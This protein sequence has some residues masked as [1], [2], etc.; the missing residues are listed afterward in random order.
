M[1]YGKLLKEALRGAESVGAE[2]K[3][4]QL[5]DLKYT[6]CKSCFGC[7]R[8]GMESFHCSLKDELT[9]VLEEIFEADAVFLGSPIYFGDLT[10][11]MVS[12]LERLEFPLCSYDD[13]SKQLFDGKV[14]VAFFHTMNAPK[15]YYKNAMEKPL[16][17]RSSELLKRLG[18]SVEVYA[19]CD[20][21]QFNDYSKYHSG[22]FDEAHKRK[23]RENQF[24]KD[25]EAA[26][27]IGRKLMSK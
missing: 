6:G 25:M 19:S 22:M 9:P 4:V 13:Y 16:E 5:Y 23:V 27:E 14:N 21:Y 10:G 17:M 26:Y 12:F 24:P 11:Q 3:L 8:K 1:E 18:G 7:K 2:T 15:E 20:T